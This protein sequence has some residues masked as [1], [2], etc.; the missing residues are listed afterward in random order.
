VFAPIPTVIAHIKSGKLR[1]L[2]VTSTKRSRALPDTPIIEEFVQGY[3]ASG[4]FGFGAPA[5]TPKE[6]V[7]TLNNTINDVISN[8]VTK[9]KLV[10]LGVGRRR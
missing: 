8:P 5:K 9:E 10:A 7:E 3:D 2:A 4:Y 1:A 6:I